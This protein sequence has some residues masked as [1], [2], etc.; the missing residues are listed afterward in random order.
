MG[1]KTLL[2]L[3]RLAILSFLIGMLLSAFLPVHLPSMGTKTNLFTTAI[4]I[5]FIIFAIGIYRIRLKKENGEK[6]P[7]K[8]ALFIDLFFSIFGSIAIAGAV[9]WLMLFLTRGRTLPIERCY[10]IAMITG[11]VSFLIMF[12][13]LVQSHRLY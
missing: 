6:P 11:V 10:D 12:I 3:L 2:S 13:R 4:A 7:I 8:T 1:Y 5:A 9:F